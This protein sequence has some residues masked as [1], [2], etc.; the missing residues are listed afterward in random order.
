VQV[1]LA[2]EKV[3]EK[4]ILSDIN[5]SNFRWWIVDAWKRYSCFLNKIGI[6]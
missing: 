1:F 2:C 4:V 5:N 6:V 3:D